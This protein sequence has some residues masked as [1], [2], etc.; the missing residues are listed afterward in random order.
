MI[1]FAR[2]INLLLVLVIAVGLYQL[3]PKRIAG[4][5][6]DDK[7][8]RL[9]KKLGMVGDPDP[10][11]IKIKRIRTGHANVDAWRVFEPEKRTFWIQVQTPSTSSI[12]PASLIGGPISKKLREELPVYHGTIFA[13]SYDVGGRSGSKIY[14]NSGSTGSMRFASK[15]AVEHSDFLK[16]HWSSMERVDLIGDE[17]KIFPST[18]SVP[19]LKFVVPEKLRAE[20][21]AEFGEGSNVIWDQDWVVLRVNCGTMSTLSTQHHGSRKNTDR[22][23]M[24]LESP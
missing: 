9:F 13:H 20:F 17:M 12:S 16:D 10:E 6:L 2:V 5:K 14:S 15:L 11:R 18:D 24:K 8:D 22:V 23:P 3:Y 1:T 4:G 7:R 21:R 19:L